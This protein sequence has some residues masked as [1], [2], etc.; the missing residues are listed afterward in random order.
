LLGVVVNGVHPMF[1]GR[2]GYTYSYPTRRG[3]VPTR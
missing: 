1:S 2:A 3:P